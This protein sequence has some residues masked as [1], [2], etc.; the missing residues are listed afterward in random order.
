[1]EDRFYR[2][3]EDR[4]RGSRE[5]ILQRLTA[6]QP[7]TQPYVALATAAESPKAVDIG[8]GR[9]E[10]LELLQ[11]QGFAA[12]GIDLDAGMLEACH[13]LKLDAV[14]GD[15]VAY[16]GQQPANSLAVVSAFHVVEHIDFELVATLAK[17]A[18]AALAPGGLLI[19]ETPNPDNI[20]VAG[21]DFYLDPTHLRPIP[22]ALLAFLLEYVGFARVKIVPLN[23]NAYF[24]EPE[25]NLSLWDVISGASPD[26]A[27]VAQKAEADGV[28]TY[29][30][31][32]NSAF[33]ADYGLSLD[34]LASQYTQ[35][36]Q[37][38]LASVL[39]QAKDMHHQQGQ[40]TQSLYTAHHHLAENY[41]N[42][43]AQHELLSTHHLALENDYREYQGYVEDRFMTIFSSA[44]WR[45]AAP[46]RYVQRQV[47]RVREK[48]LRRCL[49]RL[50][51]LLGWWRISQKFA[52]AASP[53][54]EGLPGAMPNPNQP[55]HPKDW[56]ANSNAVTRCQS[57]LE[58]WQRDHE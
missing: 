16:L 13:A 42:L 1:M 44:N 21:R 46:L 17:H 52:P 36:N 23:E 8:C 24:K 19:F 40:A 54:S 5:A 50:P 22:S 38:H 43:L 25:A 48:G 57:P 26:Y 30:Q 45:L 58:Q 2:A 7:F 37:H 32:L 35:R 34:R 55:T 28:D 18:L 33:D 51:Y 20:L 56:Q 9:G 47:R 49:R 14:L 3:F 39:A 4:Y 11:N 27:V 29:T 53:L 6:Y 41:Q 10:W 12:R 31:A 15:G